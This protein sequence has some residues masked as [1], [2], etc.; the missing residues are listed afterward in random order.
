MAVAVVQGLSAWREGH[1]ESLW[2]SLGAA[3]V[4]AL[5]GLVV[6]WLLERRVLRPIEALTDAEAEIEASHA[7][8]GL[9]DLAADGEVGRLVDGFN[10]MLGVIHARDEGLE[11]SVAIRSGEL[12]VAKHQA[13]RANRSRSDILDALSHEIGTPINGV[14]GM[15]ALLAAGDLGPRQRRLAEVIAKSAAGLTATVND[16]LNVS[17]TAAGKMT[18]EA[19]PTDVAEIA[20]DVI[21]LFWERAREKGLDLAAYVDP[22]TP[23]LIEADPVRLRQIIGA[24]V[25]NALTVTETGGVLLSVEPTP[26][27]VLRVEVRDTGAGLAK[28]RIA[29]LGLGI[30]RKLI[31]AMGGRLLV[32]SNP[33][34]GSTFGF[35]FQPTTL[36]PASDWPI[37]DGAQIAVGLA[38]VATRS[39]VRR[40]LTSAEAEICASVEGDG[41]VPP[42]AIVADPEALARLAPG[43]A[44]TV[45]IGE[46]G[47]QGP[48]E[49]K[50]AGL[51][52]VVLIQPFRRRDL[53]AVLGQLAMGGGLSEAQI[54]EAR[55]ED[56]AL[57]SFAGRRVL[58]ADDSAVGREVAM[59]ALARLGVSTAV[60]VDGR[61]A[62][63]TAFTEAF[64][65]ILMDGGLPVMDAYHAA[66][67][68][69]TAEAEFHRRR[70]PI[71]AV[72]AVGPG[73]RADTWRDAGMDGALHKPF[74][75]AALARALGSVMEPAAPGV[76]LE[77]FEPAETMAEAPVASAAPI[78]PAPGSDQGRLLQDLKMA[79]ERGEFSLVYQKQVDRDGQAVL[80]VEALLRWNHPTRGIIS[81]ALFI[82]LAEQNGLIRDITGWVLDQAIAE[83]KDLDGGLTLAVNASAV[84][85]SDPEF[86]DELAVII[87]RHAYD[88]RR[89]E[90]EIT[91]TAIMAQGD[92]ARRSM[93]RLHAMGVKI[94][95]DDFGVGYSSLSHLQL[96]PFD[97]LKIDRMFVNRCSDDVQS[98]T[99]VQA[100]V[101]IGRALGMK[102]VAE[103]VEDEMQRK[104]LRAAGAHAM[105]GFLFGRPAPVA[106]L[107]RELA[108]PIA[109]ESQ[110]A[111][112]G[113]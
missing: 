72:T 3:V 27:G 54:E 16:I 13:E 108:G 58:V 109:P 88:P 37:F 87:A 66:K 41:Q 68:I 6:A 38:G 40:Y 90:V 111:A 28:D 5:I 99:L 104:F 21:A 43:P 2:I 29:S 78:K 105:Q 83:T 23:A 92:E 110:K 71:I 91:E 47:D 77:A 63:E 107:K 8:T 44:H 89:L 14:T 65:L 1:R 60:A 82:P 33:G 86:A 85:F 73:A 94:A 75:L 112:A 84:E 74:T 39:A 64:D 34:R 102:V 36:A 4:A 67:A 46:Y 53:A 26:E 32:A 35:E 20:E 62:A 22:D 42:M 9:V 51:A 113:R 103:G 45:C 18:L 55:A 59:E 80:G 12:R 49:L 10:R 15:A 56:E 61:D 24:L 11:R 93:D 7:Y 48:A 76:E 19:T 70:T 101:S 98:A 57:P 17:K 95:L 100:L 97:K 79:R 106:E 50:R 31:E 69:R 25:N 30:C 81:P 52:Q 96:Y